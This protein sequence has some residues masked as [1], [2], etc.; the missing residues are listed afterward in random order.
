MH[1]NSLRRG[2][3]IGAGALACVA[4]AAL[5]GC[6][7]TA[8]LADRGSAAESQSR[9]VAI[10]FEWR[11]LEPMSGEP[12]PPYSCPADLPFLASTSHAS[13]GDA[14]VDGVEIDHSDD[15][16]RAAVTITATAVDE[17][18]RPVGMSAD[19]LAA[20]AVNWSSEEARY[21]VV[22]HC[23]GDGTVLPPV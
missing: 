9:P 11:V 16:H 5:A 19:P 22:L 14:L 6:A 13:F 1:T 2:L 15:D 17:T 23:V 21:R 20:S 12:I 10:A 8:T 18:G 7:T 4:A 3:R